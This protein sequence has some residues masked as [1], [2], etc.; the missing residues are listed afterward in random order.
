MAE[1]ARICRIILQISLDCVFMCFRYKRIE[2]EAKVDKTEHEIWKEYEIM[3]P[4]ARAKKLLE[5]K[6]EILSILLIV[7]ARRKAQE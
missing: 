6:Y 1:N 5:Q 7:K 2:N 3:S 4:T